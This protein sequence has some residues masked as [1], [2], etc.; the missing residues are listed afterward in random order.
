MPIGKNNYAHQIQILFQITS[1]VCLYPMMAARGP[2]GVPSAQLMEPPSSQRGG[3]PAHGGSELGSGAEPSRQTGATPPAQLHSDTSEVRR[4]A[5][6]NHSSPGLN[7]Q[8]LNQSEVS[9]EVM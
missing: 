1:L 3:P 6:A 5:S 8:P 2:R 9:I 4:E 7:T